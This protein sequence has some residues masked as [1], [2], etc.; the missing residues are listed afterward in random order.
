MEYSFFS[1]GHSNITARHKNTLEFTKDSD[2]TLQGDCIIGVNSDFDVNELKR[3]KGK[4]KILV[5]VGD[6]V[7]EINCEVNP[8][9]DDDH[10][11]VVRKG[12]FVS[13]R[14]FGINADKACCDL[15]REFVDML[16]DSG[17]RVEV[18]VMEYPV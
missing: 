5:N 16:K 1:F 4:V 17:V 14:T 6:L 7:E 12:E 13:K 9:F 18:R 11:M 8:E 15:S 3:F 10:E 2:L